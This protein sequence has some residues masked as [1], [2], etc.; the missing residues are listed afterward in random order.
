MVIEHDV[1]NEQPVATNDQRQMT[2][3]TVVIV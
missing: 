1:P 3:A 2:R